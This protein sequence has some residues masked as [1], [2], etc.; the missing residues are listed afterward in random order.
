MCSAVR[1]VRAPLFVARGGRWTRDADSGARF[2]FPG[3]DM[4]APTAST[5]SEFASTSNRGNSVR[6]ADP[7]LIY[8]PRIDA[9]RVDVFRVTDDE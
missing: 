6:Y 5:R 7:P 3:R 9:P 1:S 4:W 2:G 8:T